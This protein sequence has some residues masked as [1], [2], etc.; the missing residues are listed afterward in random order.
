MKRLLVTG[1]SG[2]LGGY[3]V[4]RLE[5]QGHPLAVWSGPRSRSAGSIPAFF[6][7][8]DLTDPAAV[9]VAFHAAAPSIV[10]H[11]AALA[12]ISDCHRNPALAWA[13]NARGTA[14]LADLCAEA[15]VRLVCVST[16]L[17][18]D[19]E[20][21]PY[22]ESDPPAPLSVY[23]QTK[24]AGEQAVLAHPGNVV[25]R[26]SLLFG[27]SHQSGPSF[28]DEQV[29]ALT[30]GREITLFEDEWRTPIDLGTAAHALVELAL[31]DQEGIFHVGGPERLSRLEIGRELAKVLEVSPD[32]VRPARREAIAAPEPRPRDTSLD[33]S[34]WRQAFGRLPWPGHAEALRFLL[35]VSL[36]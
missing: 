33:S 32:L 24:A 16:D 17:V 15:G 18:F 3:L 29:R 13:I 6:S 5:Q 23:G 35:G 31:S 34:R 19:G 36:P 7:A 14:L 9:T 11:S 10:L 2:V 27:P 22:R 4:R 26:V 30:E 8:V 28:F 21:A 1:A 25:V 12:R 20:Q